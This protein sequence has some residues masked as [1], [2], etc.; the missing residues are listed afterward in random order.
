MD[1]VELPVPRFEIEWIETPDGAANWVA[2]YRLVMPPVGASDFR[3]KNG[4]VTHTLGKLNLRT[5]KPEPWK[6][7]GGSIRFPEGVG[8][9]MVADAKVLKIPAFLRFKD[10]AEEVMP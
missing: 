7:L 4:V 5:E 6:L 8:P 10:Q 2:E 3:M 1:R 9:C